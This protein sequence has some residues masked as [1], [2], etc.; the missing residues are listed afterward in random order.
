M[1]AITS[2]PPRT[3][4]VPLDVLGGSLAGLEAARSLAARWQSRVELIHVDP[5]PPPAFAEG[6]DFWPAA[7]L[8]AMS[9]YRMF[10]TKTAPSGANR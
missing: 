5:G 9:G 10:R 7:S 8:A 4:L 6:V 1:R 2:F 3:I